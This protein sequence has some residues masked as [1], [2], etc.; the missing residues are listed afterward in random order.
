MNHFS[1]PRL[2]FRFIPIWR[3]H[4]LVWK[5]VAATSIIGHRADPIINLLGLGYGLGSLLPQMGGTS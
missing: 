1:P 3:R 5:K 2:S 4:C